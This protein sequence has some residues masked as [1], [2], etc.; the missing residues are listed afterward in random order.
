[1]NS[2]NESNTIDSTT[3]RTGV[4][5]SRTVP[6]EKSGLKSVNKEYNINNNTQTIPGQVSQTY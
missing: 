1:M 3:E 2:T 4:Q 5:D 6:P